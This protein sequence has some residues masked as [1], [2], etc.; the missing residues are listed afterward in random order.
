[1]AN[2]AKDVYIGVFGTQ[3]Y[4]VSFQFLN[5]SH[6]R[7]TVNGVVYNRP[8]DWTLNAAGSLLT[9]TN[10][11]IQT[12]DDIII[13][14]V[15]PNTVAGR[16]VDFQNGAA[17]TEADLDNSYLQLLYIAQEGIDDNVESLKLLQAS[18]DHWDAQSRRVTL[19]ADAVG[20]QDAVTKKDLEA[21]AMANGNLP[22]VTAGNNF[23]Q[24]EVIGGAFTVQHDIGRLRAG[25]GVAG[26][27]FESVSATWN[28]SASSRLA[29]TQAYKE[30]DN[31]SSITVNADS[32]ALAIGSGKYLVTVRAY[33]QNSHISAEGD[34][35][36]Y[37]T[38]EVD[39]PAQ[40]IHLLSLRNQI[41]SETSIPWPHRY[42]SQQVVIDTSGGSKTLVVRARDGA[43]SPADL[44]AVVGSFLEIERLGGS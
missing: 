31:A 41:P 5:E 33:I 21:Q 27:L 39:G 36:W 24:L 28:E 9:F 14:R 13:E 23:Q 34:Y 18:L 40:V 42:D 8:A 20:Q 38:D 25:F 29:L 32:I 37:L 3:A 26:A 2:F 22:I 4:S 16:V 19:M 7:A 11:T 15:T 35:D 44:T 30:N 12:S 43:V 1:M 10:P 17:L 6:V